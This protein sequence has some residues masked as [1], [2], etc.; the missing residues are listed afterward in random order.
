[1]ALGARGSGPSMVADGL[2][3]SWI[4]SSPMRRH[5][6]TGRRARRKVEQGLDSLLAVP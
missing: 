5:V 1:M 3:G 2:K 4:P 6:Q